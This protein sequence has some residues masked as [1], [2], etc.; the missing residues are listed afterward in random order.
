MNSPAIPLSEAARVELVTSPGCHFCGHAREVLDR[1]ATDVP[2]EVTEV[3]L[4]S[5]AGR[6][7]LARW[8]VPFPPILLVNGA[9]FG[10]GRI[11]ERKLRAVLAGKG[12]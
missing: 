2:L 5:P 9:L 3:D 1:V 7:A 8:R 6:A 11:S 12:D 10:Y 4:D